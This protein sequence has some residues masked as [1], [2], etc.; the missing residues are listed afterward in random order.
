[1]IWAITKSNLTKELLWI[2]TANG[3]TK[4]NTATE[5]FTQINIPN[6][7]H[8]QFGTS[9]AYVIEEITNADTIIWTNSYSG[10]ISY[11]ITQNFSADMY[12]IMK[13][14]AALLAIKLIM[15]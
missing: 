1:M 6:A 8:M 11:N 10:L 13:I 14:C 3:L 2:G 9:T 12:T 5:T 15:F 4:L 7:D